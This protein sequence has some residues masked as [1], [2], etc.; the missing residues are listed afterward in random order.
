MTFILRNVISRMSVIIL[1]GG[2]VRR[3]QWEVHRK[4]K[5]RG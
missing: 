4:N 3:F 2:K 5:F 1:F